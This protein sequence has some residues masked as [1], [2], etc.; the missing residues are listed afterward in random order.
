M[1]T[2]RRGFLAG[3]A[4]LVAAPA[5][6]RPGILMPVK[7]LF[8]P[9]LWN[10]GDVLF[11]GNA[12]VE[13]LVGWVCTVAGRPGTWEELARVDSLSPWVPTPGEPPMHT[14]RY[15]EPPLHLM[16]PDGRYRLL[17]VA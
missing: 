17:E 2:N 14:R 15:A 5:I 16:R 3:L 4:A 11:N 8:K 12:A 6:I 7:P 1:E 10:V 13:S 9:T